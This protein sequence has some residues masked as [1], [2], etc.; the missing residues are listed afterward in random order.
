[1]A[2]IS[3]AA[4]WLNEGKKVRNPDMPE[5]EF[6]FRRPDNYIDYYYYITERDPGEALFEPLDFLRLDWDIYDEENE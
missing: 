1:M 4:L 2:D 6:L 5:G 3:Q